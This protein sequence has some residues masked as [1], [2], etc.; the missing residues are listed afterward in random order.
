MW[1]YPQD[2]VE[3]ITQPIYTCSCNCD[4]IGTVL[5]RPQWLDFHQIEFLVFDE[6]SFVT[7][8]MEAWK[9]FSRWILSCRVVPYSPIRV[10]A[11]TGLTK[12]LC[13]MSVVFPK[14]ARVIIIIVITLHHHGWRVCEAKLWATP[15]FKERRFANPWFLE[16][17]ILISASPLVGWLCVSNRYRQLL[18]H[19]LLCCVVRRVIINTP[20]C[21]AKR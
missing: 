14:K 15:G 11:R 5:A 17:G 20:Q 10:T 6:A 7:C 4:F 3:P 2:H 16:P 8:A 13:A 19:F 1:L 21:E 9:M 12:Q 18:D